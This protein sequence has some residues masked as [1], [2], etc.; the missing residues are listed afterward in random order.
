MKTGLS[1]RL[2]ALVL[3]FAAVPTFA[4]V[5]E[6]RSMTEA[7]FH[8]L[9]ASDVAVFDLDNTIIE[10]LQSLGS[11]QW[12][13]YQ[14]KRFR[15]M[16]FPD[17]RATEASVAMF[18][19]VQVK[20]SVRLVEPDT[21]RIIREL[22]DRGVTVLG[23]TARPLVIVDRTL[24]QLASVGVNL[25]RRPVA[26]GDFFVDVYRTARFKGGVLFVGENNKGEMLKAIY[27][28]LGRDLPPVVKFFDDKRYHVENMDA[29]LSGTGVRHTSYRYGA[30]DPRVK[31]FDP[32]LGDYQWGV[33]KATGQ[34]LSDEE[35]RDRLD[36]R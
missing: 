4:D 24:A 30:A 31:S 20:S 13:S 34:I 15:E 2:S 29:A 36:R 33:F 18:A 1:R 9:G 19:E 16:G 17:A 8:V 14:G 26:S 3:A 5:V 27:S 25:D 11:D 28:Q 22:Q 6:I 10:P 23:L 12:G 21:A 7:P 35:A 32:V